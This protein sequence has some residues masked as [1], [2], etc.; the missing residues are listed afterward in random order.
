MARKQYRIV[1][2]GRL[3]DRFGAAF[4]GVRLEPLVRQTALVGELAD[5]AQLEAVLDRLRDFA[6]EVVSVDSD[7]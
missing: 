4:P 2:N 7:E 1:V 6:I 3:S 5:E